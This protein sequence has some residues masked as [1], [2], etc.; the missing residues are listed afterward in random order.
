MV[1]FQLTP[2]VLVVRYIVSCPAA[3]NN[4]LSGPVRCAPYPALNELSTI[5]E[6]RLPMAGMAEQYGHHSAPH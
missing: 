1:L 5:V 6:A 4:L 3:Y 2:S